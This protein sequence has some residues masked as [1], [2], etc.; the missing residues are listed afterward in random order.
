MELNKWYVVEYQQG[1]DV[2]YQ[3]ERLTKFLWWVNREELSDGWDI[4]FS[5]TGID[6]ARKKRN[7]M[8]NL[9]NKIYIKVLEG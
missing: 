3:V 4:L 5:T 1:E 9:N 7:E 8:N 6:E 2:W